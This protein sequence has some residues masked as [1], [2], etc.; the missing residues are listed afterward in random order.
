MKAP[1]KQAVFWADM[2]SMTFPRRN[3]ARRK[4]TGCGGLTSEEAG[5]PRRCIKNGPR[6]RAKK[7]RDFRGPGCRASGRRE[8]E[9]TGEFARGRRMGAYTPSPPRGE[10]R[11][12]GDAEDGFDGEWGLR[13]SWES[14]L[15]DPL[16]LTLSPLSADQRSACRVSAN[17][18]CA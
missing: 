12:E 9:A 18:V 17:E 14:S 5:C 6:K 1:R 2:R 11:G 8:T 16:T 3:Q 15:C 13:G 10:G 7:F 4:A